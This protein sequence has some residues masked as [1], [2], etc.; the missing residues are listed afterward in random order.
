MEVLVMTAIYCGRHF[1]D[2]ELDR[3][4]ELGR[5]LPSR[6]AIARAVCTEFGWRKPDG[7]LKDMSCRVALLRMHREGLITLP[8]PQHPVNP[9][10]RTPSRAARA[11]P[12]GPPLHGSRGDIAQLTLD[13]VHGPAA[14]RHWNDLVAHYH[15]LGYSPLPG[16]QMRY[17]IHGDGVLLGVLGF[18]AA[19]WKTAPRDAFIGWTPEQRKAHLHLVVNNARF[20]LLPW[21]SI[22]YLASSVL[23]LAARQL[24]ADWAQR[25]AYRPVL[26]DRTQCDKTFAA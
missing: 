7:G 24:P 22:R 15:Y 23:A 3:I 4:R 13:P 18:G 17:F 21:V 14:S 26:M 8:P 10:A 5:I 2:R 16:A 6:Q 19:A 20:L 25:F 11:I 1:T 9:P 12:F